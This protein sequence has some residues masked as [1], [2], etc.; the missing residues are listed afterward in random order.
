MEY[1]CEISNPVMANVEF[2]LKKIL[3]QY[4][5]ERAAARLGVSLKTIHN[6]LNGRNPRR[7]TLRKI[8]DLYEEI[9]G[10]KEVTVPQKQESREEEVIQLLKEKISWLE[11]QKV[12]LKKLLENQKLMRAYLH[13]TH[14]HLLKIRA[15]VEKK[16]IHVYIQESDKLLT[17]FLKE[18]ANNDRSG[19]D[20]SKPYN[21][22]IKVK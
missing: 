15:K 10:N 11:S 6:A 16:D 8:K 4:T 12:D 14:E 5:Q 18:G 3:E 21:D 20:N 1:N 17:E 13:V 19:T 7:E 2:Y 22:K 9:T